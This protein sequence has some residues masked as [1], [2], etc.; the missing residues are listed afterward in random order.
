MIVL[1]IMQGVIDK[2][3]DNAAHAGG[4]AGGFLLALLLYHPH[5]MKNT[6]S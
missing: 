1:M 5:A 4:L 3:V 2:G 6:G